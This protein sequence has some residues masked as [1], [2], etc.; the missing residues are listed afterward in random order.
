MNPETFTE[1]WNWLL[2]LSK[3]QLIILG[4]G[5]ALLVAVSK[6]L[7]FFFL[8]AVVLLFLIVFLPRLLK[9][10]EESPL[11]AV[12]DSAIQKGIDATQDPPSGSSAPPAAS[13]PGPPSV[14]ASPPVSQR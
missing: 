11:P 13:P 9:S 8:V 10:Y 7:R 2:G 3:V 4:G 5:V 14:P 6:F 12:V 1:I